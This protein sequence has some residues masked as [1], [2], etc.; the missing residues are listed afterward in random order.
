MAA[1]DSSDTIAAL[2][3][4]LADQAARAAGAV[5]AAQDHA[6]ALAHQ[7][8]AELALAN[9]RIAALEQQVWWLNHWE[10]DPEAFMS[11][12]RG[13]VLWAVVRILRAAR[14]Q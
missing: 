3:A 4:E 5:A 10:F 1:T 13:R 11:T 12:R 7:H 2:Q 9:A 6:A 8:A 14:R